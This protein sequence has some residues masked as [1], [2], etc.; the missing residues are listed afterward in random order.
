MR[1]HLAAVGPLIL[2]LPGFQFGNVAV[3]AIGITGHHILKIGNGFV[4]GALPCIADHTIRAFFL[5][6]KQAF[7]EKVAGHVVG[8]G[9]IGFNGV[10]AVGAKEA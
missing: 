8:S 6:G 7:P 9:T 10:G 2:M 3:H 5:I 4:A 1:G